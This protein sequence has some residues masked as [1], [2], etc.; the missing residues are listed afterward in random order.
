MQFS[1]TAGQI[2]EAISDLPVATKE[3]D[4]EEAEA[5]KGH[6]ES[7][8]DEHL[9]KKNAAPAEKKN[10][11]E[12]DPFGLDAFLP[13]SLKK[14]ERAKVK[15]DVV[16]KTRN[17]EEVEAKNFL[18]AQRGALISCLEIAAHRYRIPWYKICTVQN[19]SSLHCF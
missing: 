10:Q 8:D 13:G 5:L 15:N 6:E 16:S 17:D 12:S 1:K 14:G 18:K 3:D 2:K 4:S 9:K 11:E 19:D 7:T